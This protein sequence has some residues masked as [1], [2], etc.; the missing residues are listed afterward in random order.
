MTKLGTSLLVVF[1]ITGCGGKK[2]DKGG[3]DKAGGGGG[4]SIGTIDIAAVN[5][6]VPKELKDKLVFEQKPIVLERGKH[7]T[8]Y[9]LAVPKGW[10]QEGKMF[11]TIKADSNGGFFS[12][13]KISSDCDGA[14]E[15]KKWEAI[16]DKNFFVEQL[17]GKVIKD[18]KGANQRLVVADTDRNGVKTTNVVFAWWQEGAKSYH[19]CTANLDEAIKAAAPAF[20]KA[21]QAV[22]VEGD[23]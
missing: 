3:G 12:G 15:P 17:K 18:E 22:T 16:A 10:T 20:E 1:A 2:D 5:A 8:T 7:P 21:C 19:V 6:L 9:T 13:M 4:A 11:G 14:C 23:D